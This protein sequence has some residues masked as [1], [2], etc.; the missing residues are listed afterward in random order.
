[1]MVL[2]L[3]ATAVA[4]VLGDAV[5]IPVRIDCDLVSVRD[6]DKTDRTK[7]H[8]ALLFPYDA[9]QSDRG[10]EIYALQ[11]L[12]DGRTF[13]LPVTSSA[14]PQGDVPEVKHRPQNAPRLFATTLDFGDGETAFLR[15]NA[16]NSKRL[17]YE[18]RIHLTDGGGFVVTRGTC[19][20]THE[21]ESQ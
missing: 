6:Q 17:S 10:Y 21:A 14:I 11:T 19:H 1:M 18:Q 3:A 12:D 15:S 20:M 8:M 2:A 16:R 7:A 9:K 5:Y 13:L 4:P